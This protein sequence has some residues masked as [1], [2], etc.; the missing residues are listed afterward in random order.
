MTYEQFAAEVETMIQNLTA[1][2]KLGGAGWAHKYH[3]HSLAACEA[4]AEIGGFDA[5]FAKMFNRQFREDAVKVAMEMA[6]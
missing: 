4:A 6:A 5:T 2:A 3:D 1:V